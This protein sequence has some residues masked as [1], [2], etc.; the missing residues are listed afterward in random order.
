MY[1]KSPNRLSVQFFIIDLIGTFCIVNF[2]WFDEYLVFIIDLIGTFCIVNV[3]LDNGTVKTFIDL[4]GTF[5]IVNFSLARFEKDKDYR[6]NRNILY[7]KWGTFNFN[8][9]FG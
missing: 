2:I 7:C 3:K 8:W 4:I 9:L 5:C 6:F 1:C